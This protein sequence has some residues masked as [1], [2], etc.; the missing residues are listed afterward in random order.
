[1][2]QTSFFK[3]SLTPYYSPS[4]DETSCS[5]SHNFFDNELSNSTSRYITGLLCSG[6]SIYTESTK[7]FYKKPILTS[8]PVARSIAPYGGS[9]PRGVLSKA[10]LCTK[11]L[12]RDNSAYVR[13]LFFRFR[14]LFVV[15]VVIHLPTDKRPVIRLDIESESSLSKKF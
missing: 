8:M 12:S 5:T 2:S 4:W 13:M 3:F 9:A 15:F 1:M 6:R 11:N 10:F 14:L 7:S